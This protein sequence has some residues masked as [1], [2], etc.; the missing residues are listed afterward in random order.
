MLFLFVYPRLT[1][2]PQE[3]EAQEKAQ[4]GAEWV[5][6]VDVVLPEELEQC[7]YQW[8]FATVE[9]YEQ[10]EARREQR[11]RQ[12]RFVPARGAVTSFR[13]AGQFLKDYHTLDHY[14]VPPGGT[15][16][17]S[18]RFPETSELLQ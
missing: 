6:P 5:D 13:Y 1:V 2:C 4:L 7:Y 11:A 14:G 9:E 8:G 10:A 12:G 16:T 18:L 3:R 17:H 15:I